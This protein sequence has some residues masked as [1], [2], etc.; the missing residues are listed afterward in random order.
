MSCKILFLESSYPINT[1]SQRII[2]SLTD[3][4]V[5]VCTW[6]RA[7]DL[8]DSV[9]KYSVF[10]SPNVGYGNRLGK[11]TALFKYA[12]FYKKVSKS[13][14]PDIIISSHWDMLIISALFKNRS[15]LIYDN[16]DIPEFSISVVE[17]L[18][19]FLEKLALK[20]VNCTLL[21]SRFYEPLYP[22]NNN[23]I[24][25]N[26]P[27]AIDGFKSCKK[28]LSN[29]Q[30]RLGFVGSVRHYDLLRNLII[31]AQD[32]GNVELHIYGTGIVE[33]KLKSFCQKKHITSVIFH[34]RFQYDE[35]K[36]I[37]SKLDILWAAYPYKSRNVKY[38]ISN[39]FYESIYYS[40]PC[41]FSENTMLGEYVV[42]NNLGVS[43]NPYSVISIKEGVLKAI[44]SY[45][46]LHN[47]LSKF[48]SESAVT[49]NKNDIL[50]KTLI[51]DVIV[52]D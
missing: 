8:D 48:Q 51:K 14:K 10:S 21:A 28:A 15:K 2:D 12:L 4:D 31:S 38:A 34:G 25:E 52:N 1:R 13:F 24:L 9:N 49:W 6:D 19:V 17:K 36:S 50:I 32:I 18:I 5:H 11:L 23:V 33:D 22:K 41:L 42:S 35:I 26:L 29:N 43:V 30:I 40:I 47:N 27:L 37:Y 44:A 20:R 46:E 16:V 3:Y 39:K 7:G 45:D